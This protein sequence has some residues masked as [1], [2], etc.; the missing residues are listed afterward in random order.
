M[1]DLILLAL[2]L[3][4]TLVVMGVYVVLCMYVVVGD[5]VVWWGS[6]KVE[7][8][9]VCALNALAVVHVSELV[10]DYDSVYVSAVIQAWYHR[11]RAMWWAA[12]LGYKYHM[13]AECVQGGRCE[14]VC[15]RVGVGPPSPHL[16]A[17]QTP[18]LKNFVIRVGYCRCFTHMCFGHS[19]WSLR[20]VVPSL[21]FQC[22]PLV[23]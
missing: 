19:G 22:P 10:C 9:S 12:I 21:R 2:T 5:V 6:G 4:P 14:V 17:S 1:N 23:A 20:L 8:H 13:R 3:G 16:W 11:A 15:D 7:Y 18:R